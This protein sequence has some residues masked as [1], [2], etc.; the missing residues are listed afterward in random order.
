MIVTLN[1]HDELP[2]E[3][4]AVHVTEVVPVTNVE[5]DAGTQTT[6]AAGVE[7]GVANVTT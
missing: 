3:L 4:I 5:P 6:V 7:V 2:H 1:E